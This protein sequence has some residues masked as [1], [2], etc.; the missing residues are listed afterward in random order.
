MGA[1]K[2][3][4][5][6]SSLQLLVGVRKMEFMAIVFISGL[7]IEVVNSTKSDSLTRRSNV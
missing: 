7:P 4:E 6:L 2:L 3:F 1:I 5:S